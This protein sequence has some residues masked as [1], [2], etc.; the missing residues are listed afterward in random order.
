MLAKAWSL[1]LTGIAPEEVTAGVPAVVAS[2]YD[3]DRVPLPEI[4]PG[5]PDEFR[6]R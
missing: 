1:G 2:N 4:T 3:S 5:G 6:P